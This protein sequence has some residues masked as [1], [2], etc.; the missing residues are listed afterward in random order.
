M[1]EKTVSQ[2]ALKRAD[3][4]FAKIYQFYS[5]VRVLRKD[6]VKFTYSEFRKITDLFIN[7]AADLQDIHEDEDSFESIP[8]HLMGLTMRELTSKFDN[9]GDLE[10][11]VK[12]L[13]DLIEVDERDQALRDR[14]A[15]EALHKAPSDGQAPVG[16]HQDDQTVS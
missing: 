1:G 10:H 3:D 9:F 5:A 7:F 11:Y 16:N 12:M 13:K 2:G 14:K 8:Q 6:N 15:A 4:V